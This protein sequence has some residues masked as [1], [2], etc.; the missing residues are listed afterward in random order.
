MDHNQPLTNSEPGPAES[1]D[2]RQARLQMVDK[3]LRARGIDDERVLEAMARVPRH[4]FVPGDWRRAAY[5]DTAL[6]LACDQ[7]VS[8]PFTVAFMCQA[9]RLDGHER[10]LEVGTGSGYGAAVLSHLAA[11]VHSVERIPPL[12]ERARTL[13]ARLGYNNVTVHTADGTLGLP[14]AAPFD[15]IVVTA[16]AEALPKAYLEQLVDGGRIIIPIGQRSQG[17]T[18]FRF[19]LRNHKLE[20][21]DLGGFA[22]VPLIGE[23]GSL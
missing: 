2:D 18:M 22:F 8:Q 12:A 7:T 19:T 14:A 11:E 5:S 3:Q 13:L 1:D 16:G 10:V 15:A 20:V 21:E 17:Q 9:A 4:E 23:G 6:P